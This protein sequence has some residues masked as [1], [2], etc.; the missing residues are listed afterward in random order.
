MA[1]SRLTKLLEE[2]E[3]IFACESLLC[4]VEFLSLV[5]ENFLANL[6]MPLES[7]L[8]ESSAAIFARKQLL[9]DLRR[10]K[11]GLWFNDRL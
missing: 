5:Y 3:L 7:S 6:F 4:R 10:S 1:S 9:F 2:I 8:D 11:L